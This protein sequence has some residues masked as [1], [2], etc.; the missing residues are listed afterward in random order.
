MNDRPLPEKVVEDKQTNLFL[1]LWRTRLSLWNMTLTL[2]TIETVKTAAWQVLSN[3]HMIFVQAVPK[4]FIP[5]PKPTE[6]MLYIFVFCKINSQGNFKEYYVI[7]IWLEQSLY[8][9]SFS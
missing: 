6:E 5:K 4:K 2:N 9:L 8:S 1:A 3:L 7:H